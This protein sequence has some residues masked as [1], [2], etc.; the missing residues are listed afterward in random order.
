MLLLSHADIAD[1]TVCQSV[2]HIV[3]TFE[4][5]IFRTAGGAGRSRSHLE[6]LPRLQAMARKKRSQA[7]VYQCLYSGNRD[8]IGT[9]RHVSRAHR[10][11]SRMYSNRF[12]A[13][14]YVVFPRKTLVI[15]KKNGNPEL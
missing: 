5:N 1:Y 14:G 13:L 12:A 6:P 3:F 2:I 9:T 7:L 15:F 11:R 8:V 10:W 4:P